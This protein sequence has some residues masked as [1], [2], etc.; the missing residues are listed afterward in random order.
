MFDSWSG[1][2]NERKKHAF[3]DHQKYAIHATTP[4]KNDTL[5]IIL[6]HTLIRKTWLWMDAWHL[7]GGYL[8]FCLMTQQICNSSGQ[9]TTHH[10]TITIHTSIVLHQSLVRKARLC[11]Q[12]FCKS[13]YIHI[14]YSYLMYTRNKIEM[15]IICKYKEINLLAKK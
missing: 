2:F 7:L 8:Y 6:H 12:A 14:Y 15:K 3:N 10:K 13:T 9:A 11:I 5:Y 4:Q 1:Y